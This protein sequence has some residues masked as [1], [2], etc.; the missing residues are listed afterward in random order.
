VKKKDAERICSEKI[1]EINALKWKYI[2]QIE[3]WY[4]HAVRLP[5]TWLDE[6]HYRKAGNPEPPSPEAPVLKDAP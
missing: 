1:N 6:G 3:A 5:W 4:S 2:R